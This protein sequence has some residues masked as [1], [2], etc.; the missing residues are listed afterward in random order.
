MDADIKKE[1]V[2]VLTKALSLIKREDFVSLK[3]L[4]NHVI[5]NAAI[6]QDKDSIQV[7][8]IIYSL[9][10]ILEREK[11]SGKQISA[12]L[13]IEIE[14]AVSRLTAF[15]ISI[16]RLADICFPL[17]FSLSRIFAKE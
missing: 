5:D 11:S 2:Y 3:E 13:N 9:A 7:A 17:L 1:I 10:K 14:K 15:S 16:F 12:S 4:S 6:Y 8:V